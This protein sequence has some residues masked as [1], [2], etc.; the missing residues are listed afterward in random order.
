MNVADHPCGSTEALWRCFAEPVR[1]FL[2]KRTGS[3]ADSDDLLQEVFQRVHR[4]LPA[5]HHASHL[6]GWVYQIARNVLADHYRKRR[7]AVSLDSLAD[8][9]PAVETDALGAAELDLGPT[10]K[11][12]VTELPVR[13]R[14]PLVRHEFQGQSLQEVA[15]AEGLTLT[16]TKSRVRRARLL[17]REMLDRCCRFEFDRNGKVIDMI[18]R[19]T[20]ACGAK[21]PGETR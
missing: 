7:I 5:L 20:C 8:V 12:F 19:S 9:L 3:D 10:V 14:D 13:Y 2:L 1:G 16:A 4:A 6:Q 21:R 18:P 17:L 15:D 11:R